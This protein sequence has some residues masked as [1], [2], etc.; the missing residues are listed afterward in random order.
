MTVRAFA[1]L[2]PT[3]AL[4]APAAMAQTPADEWPHYVAPVPPTVSAQAQAPADG[5]HA[6]VGEMRAAA[7]KFTQLVAQM[8]AASGTEK[9][10][11]MAAILSELV[12]KQQKMM[13]CMA[14]MHEG[15]AMGAMT[16]N[17]PADAHEQHHPDATVK[18]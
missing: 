9:I 2:I 17:P 3:L 12:A 14:R 13:D 7:E 6:R 10:A 5:H 1:I 18:P 11:P 15:G 8:N 4:W 16:P